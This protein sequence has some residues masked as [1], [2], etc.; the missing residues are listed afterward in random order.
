MSSIQKLVASYKD[1]NLVLRIVTGLII[2]AILGFAA[3]STAG[4]IAA[5]HNSFL[6][7]VVA[8]GEILGNLFV[9]ALKAVAPILVFILI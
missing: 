4:D 6:I 5:E 3:R 8:F 2:G 7:N 9:G 1:K